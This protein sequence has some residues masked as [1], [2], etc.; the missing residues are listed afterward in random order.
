MLDEMAWAL[1]V[2]KLFQECQKL[3]GS[4]QIFFLAVETNNTGLLNYAAICAHNL[5]NHAGVSL[6][7][8]RFQGNI[9]MSAREY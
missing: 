8:S 2:V 5:L 3:W 6:T 4:D 9:H 7:K 1:F